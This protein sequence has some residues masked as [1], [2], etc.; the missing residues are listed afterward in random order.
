MVNVFR[1]GSLVSNLFNL[2]LKT[3]F[4]KCSIMNLRYVCVNCTRIFRIISLGK[5]ITFYILFLFIRNNDSVPRIDII[6]LIYFEIDDMKYIINL[7]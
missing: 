4:S 7:R 1:H 2:A 5:Q 6:L 3:N